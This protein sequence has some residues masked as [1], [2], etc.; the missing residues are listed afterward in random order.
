[1]SAL[2]LFFLRSHPILRILYQ[3]KATSFQVFMIS[4]STKCSNQ[5]FTNKFCRALDLWCITNWSRGSPLPTGS[6]VPAGQSLSTVQLEPYTLLSYRKSSVWFFIAWTYITIDAYQKLQVNL[7]EI[8]TT[9]IRPTS[10]Q[11]PIDWFGVTM[12]LVIT[13]KALFSCKKKREIQMISIL[14]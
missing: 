6:E 14:I 4:H 2:N 11:I 7:T 10:G 12:R 8:T 3:S 13:K 5:L 1:M 9:E